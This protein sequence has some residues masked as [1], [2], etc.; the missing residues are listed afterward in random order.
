MLT[1]EVVSITKFNYHYH[2]VNSKSVTI[3][4]YCSDVHYTVFTVYSYNIAIT[5]PLQE[6]SQKGGGGGGGH[7]YIVVNMIIV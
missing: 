7:K 2:V 5:C 6:D 1:T 3:T 4:M